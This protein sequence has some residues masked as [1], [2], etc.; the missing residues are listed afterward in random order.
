MRTFVAVAVAVAGL[1]VSVT[2][3]KAADAA[4]AGQSTIYVFSDRKTDAESLTEKQVQQHDQVFAWMERDMANLLVKRGGY[5]AE[6]IQSRDAYKPTPGS[7][8][9]V[10]RIVRYNPGAKAARMIVGFGAGAVSLDTHYEL[11]GQGK[12]PLLSKDHGVGSGREWMNCCRKLNE[13]MLAAINE[14]LAGKPLAK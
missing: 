11:Y 6:V 8:L 9:L 2:A 1:A 3:A 14:A 5:K 12:E 10:T 4:A 7:Y 13:Q